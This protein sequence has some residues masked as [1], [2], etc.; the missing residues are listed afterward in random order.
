MATG[1]VP[2]RSTPSAAE[3]TDAGAADDV[4]ADDDDDTEAELT[5]SELLVVREIRSS[6]RRTWP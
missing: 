4:D 1:R 5:R 6:P 3:E 2:L